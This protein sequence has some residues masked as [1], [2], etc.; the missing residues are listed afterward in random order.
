MFFPFI[1]T[2]IALLPAGSFQPGTE[3]IFL[4]LFITTVLVV[5]H[6]TPVVCETLMKSVSNIHLLTFF[7]LS[8][9]QNVSFE[10]RKYENKLNWNDA[11]VEVFHYFDLLN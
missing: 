2:L 5:K 4:L 7:V 9:F 1:V 8:R 11:F 3:E 6:Y 10:L